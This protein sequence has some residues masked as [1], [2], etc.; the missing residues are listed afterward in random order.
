MT[1]EKS[2]EIKYEKYKSRDP[3]PS[4]PAAL[5]NSADIRSYVDT[6][7]MISPFYDGDLKTAS[8]AARIAGECRVWNGKNNKFEKLELNKND[9]K[10][11]LLPNSIAFIG[12][13]PTFRLPDYIA[14]RFNLAISH[15]Y[16]G[17]LL[18]TGP[19][20]DPGFVGKIYIP[21]HNL[22]SNKY[23]FAY[24]EK[25]IW[26]EFTKTS[27]IPCAPKVENEVSRCNKFS[28]FPEDKKEQELKDYL[29]KALEKTSYTDVV[30]SL[31]PIV[32][33]AED[34]ADKTKKL[35]RKI[36]GWSIIGTIGV[37]VGIGSLL[38]SSWTLQ[39]NSLREIRDQMNLLEKDLYLNA[40]NEKNDS[41][42]INDISQ[43]STNLK[44]RL[45]EQSEIISELRKRITL[46]E[47]KKK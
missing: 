10:I 17:L 12:I 20:I 18:G 30:S 14:L 1:K 3:F 26:I 24:G 2:A 40:S 46:L 15:V 7:G 21:L 19:L 44:E 29:R 6:T 39:N 36:R 8:Y 38:Y 23:E 33:K 9:D 28:P 22:T 11:T 35:L 25:L 32:K 31:P 42:R 41:R 16:K 5:L 27:P 37:I 47:D 13:E 4:I 43:S 34:S 45:K